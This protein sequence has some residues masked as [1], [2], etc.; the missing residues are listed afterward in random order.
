MIRGRLFRIA[1]IMIALAVLNNLPL[2]L[3]SAPSD[4]P[5][6]RGPEATG[7]SSSANPPIRWS[8]SENVQWKS[9]IPGLGHSS[10]IVWKDSIFI[11]T[12]IPFGPPLE[13]P[14]WSGAPGAHNNLSVTQ[15]HRFVVLSFDRQTGKLNWSKTV[16]EAL[17]HAGGHET[18]SL[19]SASCST[20]GHTLIAFFGSQGLYGLNLQGEI[21]W[22]HTFGKMA[23][24]HGHGEGSSPLLHD[25][26]VYV[27]WDH[28]GQSSMTAFDAKSGQPLW[29]QNR[30]E[31]TSWATPIAIRVNGRVQIIASGTEAIKAYHPES[32]NELWWGGRLSDNIVASPVYAH[33]ILV[34]GSSYDRRAMVAIKAEKA[35]GHIET[36]KAILWERSRLT[37]YVPSPLI[38]GRHVYFLRHYQNILSRVNLETGLDEGGPYRLPGVRDIYASP[39]AVEDRLYLVDREGT[40]LVMSTGREPE[41][42]AVNRLDDAFSASPALAGEDFILR[43]EKYLY[44]IAVSRST[45]KKPME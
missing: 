17:P 41:M 43:G 10:P 44:R 25:N 24:K 9:S 42:L 21:R 16:K 19:A 15:R 1:T 31:K 40:T 36:S 39:V 11:T 5:Q 33:G 22:R 37:P 28:E 14:Q 20:D 7:F 13:K 4:W 6:W 30:D 23:T 27:N 38:V 32:G 35:T 12:A 18:G 3:F 29:Q 8:E 34:A 45:K 26:R 2:P